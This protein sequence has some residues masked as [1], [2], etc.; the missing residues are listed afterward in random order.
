MRK[1][2][3]LLASVGLLVLAA[4]A[5]PAEGGVLRVIVSASNGVS[6]L[7]RERVADMF[8]KKVTTWE[9]GTPVA[10][11]DQ[12]LA[13]GVRGRFSKEILDR[14]ASAVQRYWEERIFSGRGQ[15]PPI[16]RS[17]EEVIEFVEGNVG[18]IGYVS[19]AVSLTRRVKVLRITD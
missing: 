5:P 16:K 11:V 13:S 1:A 12:S 18:A 2:Q 4:S 19:E 10:S 8:L 7:P 17:D 15:P 9:D 6:S 14:S 3:A